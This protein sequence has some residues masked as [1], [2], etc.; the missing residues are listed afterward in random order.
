MKRGLDP[1]VQIRMSFFDQRLCNLV[2]GEKRRGYKDLFSQLVFI[3]Y[4]G[5][6]SLKLVHG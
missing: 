3:K 2:P 6:G 1:E 4:V 5:Q